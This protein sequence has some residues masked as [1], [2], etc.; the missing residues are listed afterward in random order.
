[1]EVYCRSNSCLHARL[2]ATHFWGP[3]FCSF[4][5]LNK[6]NRFHVWYT[7]QAIFSVWQLPSFFN[8]DQWDIY[9]SSYK[10]QWVVIQLFPGCA[11]GAKAGTSWDIPI[12]VIQKSCIRETLNLPLTKSLQYIWE[13]VFCNGTDGQILLTVNWN[14][15][16]AN[17]VNNIFS[18]ELNYTFSRTP[19]YEQRT[20]GVCHKIS[21][22]I[23]GG[24]E[25]DNIMLSVLRWAFHYHLVLRI[26]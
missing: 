7:Y 13:L 23:L 18:F 14:G 20:F 26:V 5:T 12:K 8:S 25:G 24:G 11:R 22:P 2:M 1:M 15:F 19:V 16:G 4:F 6:T 21:L 9:L 10:V 3:Y 17:S